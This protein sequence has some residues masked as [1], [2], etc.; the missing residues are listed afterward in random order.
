MSGDFTKSGIKLLATPKAGGFNWELDITKDPNLDPN[1]DCEGDKCTA[2]SE[3]NLKYWNMPGHKVTYASGQPDGI[4]NRLSIYFTGGKGHKQTHTWKNQTGF[5]W[6]SGDPK[7]FIVISTIRP[8]NSLASNIHHEASI[9]C[10]GGVHSGKGDPRASTI[11]MTHESGTAAP[12]YAREYNHP[13]YDYH[14][15]DQ[16]GPNAMQ[17]NMVADKWFMRQLVSKI[18]TDGNVSYEYYININPFNND[19]TVN[20][21]NWQLY[22]KT[23]DKDGFDTGRYKVAA[24][25]SAFLTTARTDGY[26]DIDISH[27]AFIE[28]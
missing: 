5:L 10:R 18:Q 14:A 15:V 8:H 1:F 4:T 23:I 11:E 24:K 7:S 21:D 26:K 13:R 12:R 19:G 3:G 22:S 2:K 25:W 17:L 28:I 6:K 9:K 20:N 16:A 27:H